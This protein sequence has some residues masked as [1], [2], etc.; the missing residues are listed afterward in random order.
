MHRRLTITTIAVLAL[1]AASVAT[2]AG[3]KE[4]SDWSPAINLSDL[5]GTSPDLNTAALEGCPIE[6][7]DA[8]ELYLASNRPGGLGGIDIWVARRATPHAPWGAPENLGAPINSEYD[9]FCPSPMRGNRFFFVSNR[10]SECGD[11]PGRGADI[12]VAKHHPGRGFDAPQNVGCHVNSAAVEASPYFL[13]ATDG[14]GELYF[15][16]NRPGPLTGS[17]LYV[18]AMEPGGSFEPPQLVPGVNS[19]YDDARPNLRRDGLELVFDSTRPGGEGGADVYLATRSSRHGPW[20]APENLGPDVNSPANDTRPSLS[21][22]GL[23]LY[24]GSNRAGSAGDPPSADVHV[25]TRQR[26]TGRR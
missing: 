17:N 1:L 3:A 7:P 18:S 11:E 5:A 13:Q 8:L 21:W 23:R 2:M 16:S 26:V 12:Y 9:D 25:A 6:S 14:P 22:D 10:P 4:L 24:L 19:P 15:S 20:T